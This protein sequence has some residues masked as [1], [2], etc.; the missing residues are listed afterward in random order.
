[1]QNGFI[2]RFGKDEIYKIILAD[3][4]CGLAVIETE[5]LTE[6]EV[7]DHLNNADVYKRLSQG[8]ARSQ[9]M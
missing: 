5:H 8:E 7:G 1:M 3:K 4:N 2:E 6:R 9:L